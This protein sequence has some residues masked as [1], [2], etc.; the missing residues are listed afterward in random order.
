[1][2]RQERMDGYAEYTRF[3]EE[4]ARRGHRFT[5]GAETSEQDRAA[6]TRGEAS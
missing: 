4:L 3:G 1:M 6:S 5:G 2:S